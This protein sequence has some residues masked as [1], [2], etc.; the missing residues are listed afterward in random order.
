[1]TK[2]E[3]SIE[4]ERHLSGYDVW[5][6]QYP[7]L[8]AETERDRLWE[9]EQAFQALVIGCAEHH[10]DWFRD[11]YT[12]LDLSGPDWLNVLWERRP[13][14]SDIVELMRLESKPDLNPIFERWLSVREFLIASN[15]RLVFKVAHRH[16]ERGLSL[17]DLAQEGQ[18][19]L[20]RALERFRCD[21][22]L[23]FSTYATHWITQY[24]RLAIKK[25]TRT[26]PIPTN[27]QD[28][29]ARTNRALARAQ[30]QQGRPVSVTEFARLSNQSTDAAEHLMSL[31]APV[32]SLDERLSDDSE[33]SALD[34][35]DSDLARPESEHE[36]SDNQERVQ[37]L[38]AHLTSREQQILAMRYG[39]GMGAEYGY[40]EIADQLNL[41]RERVRQL[42][43][44]ALG[45]LRAQMEKT[46][47]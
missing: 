43:K 19:G 44:Q 33:V 42:E 6:D 47:H 12:T 5:S 9:H 18:F 14:G 35:L 27:V 26:V 32:Q 11:K 23:R 15:I 37:A 3:L 22:E 28:D 10:P 40:R 24:I 21:K 13:T 36:R 46:T 20:V 4:I 34:L 16:T 25:Q 2:Q 30:Q 7:L 17:L 39:I 8:S 41:S 38:L 29:L 45:F 1:M 31:N